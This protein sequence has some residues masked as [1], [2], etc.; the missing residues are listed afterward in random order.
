MRATTP[1]RAEWRDTGLSYVKY[2]NVC[3][4]ALHKAVKDSRQSKYQRY[5][6]VGYWAQ[7]QDGSGSFKK[8]ERI[9]AEIAD[10][11]NDHAATAKE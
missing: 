1:L 7:E 5:S 3:T 6:V 8:I 11:A 9:P 2:L 4:S 10:Y